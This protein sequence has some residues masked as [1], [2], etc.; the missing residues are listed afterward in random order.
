MLAAGAA[1]S[2]ADEVVKT[3]DA[4]R[5]DPRQCGHGKRS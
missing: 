3:D 1:E 5:I 2:P 4:G